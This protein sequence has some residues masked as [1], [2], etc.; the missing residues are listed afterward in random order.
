MVLRL[1]CA[2][3]PTSSFALFLPMRESGTS[4][5]EALWPEAELA[6][7]AAVNNRDRIRR[8]T[9]RRKWLVNP[10]FRLNPAPVKS[11]RQRPNPNRLPSQ[12]ADMPRTAT[13]ERPK[14]DLDLSTDQSAKLHSANA[15][16][17]IAIVRACQMVKS[18]CHFGRQRAQESSAT[19]KKF[20][21]KAFSAN[22]TGSKASGASRHTKPARSNRAADR[23]RL[24]RRGGRAAGDC[25]M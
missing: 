25:Q 6:L 4:E 16:A 21:P 9:P 12:N 7:P 20:E 1:A 14:P 15:M 23:E 5:R 22:I 24:C 11:N 19:L 10:N 17:T 13:L 8:Q 2:A 18:T 3:P